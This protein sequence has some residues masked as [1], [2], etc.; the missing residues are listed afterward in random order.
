MEVDKA[1]QAMG[2]ALVAHPLAC[3]DDVEPTQGSHGLEDGC[4]IAKN[5]WG[6]CIVHVLLL[7]VAER[8]ISI[9]FP[10]HEA[11]IVFA[12]QRM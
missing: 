7:S 6:L 8:L 2:L 10:T 9:N 12:S 1:V 11:W 4:C 5:L 3:D